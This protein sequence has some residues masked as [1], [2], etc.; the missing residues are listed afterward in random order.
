MT[1]EEIQEMMKFAIEQHVQAEARMT[2]IEDVVLRLANSAESRLSNPDDKVS[3]LVVAQIKTEERLSTLAEAQ[4]LTERN[5]S[6]LA[7]AQV[8]TDQRLN[9]LIDIISERRNGT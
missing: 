9:V 3:M 2:K 8:H 1:N 7:D 6:E 4:A 5:L